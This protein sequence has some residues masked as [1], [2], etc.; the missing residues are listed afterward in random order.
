MT[1]LFEKIIIAKVK[2]GQKKDGVQS[3][4]DILLP[5]IRE[6][7]G[8]IDTTI[9]NPSHSSMTDAGWQSDY[10]LLCEI[11]K[12]QS[13]YI[14]L[15]GDHSIGQSSVAASIG[16]MDNINNLYVIW[17]DAHADLNTYEASKTKNYHGMP[18]AGIVG[19]EDSWFDIK[20]K[21]PITN[22]LYFGIRDLDDFEV[23]QIEKDNI[24]HTLKLSEIV[25]KVNE[26]LVSNPDAKFHISWD[27]DSLDPFF[28]DSTG[29]LAG[30][31]LTPPDVHHLLT[32]VLPHSIAFDIVEFNPSI[33]DLDKSI[34][35]MK[36]IINGL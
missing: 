36:E 24:F 10:K 32:N 11:L 5:I 7:F 17:I 20:S 19:Y 30:G 9:F 1:S 6:K 31:G 23:E 27:V 13:K 21:L 2:H 34:S 29:C 8:D 16:R 33:G 28:L 12:R 26:I 3:G 4:G 15:G 18:L 14:L 35:T 22:L 25:D